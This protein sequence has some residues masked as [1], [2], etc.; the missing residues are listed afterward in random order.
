[1][2]NDLIRDLGLSKELL[3]L[4][5]SRLY[6]KNMLQK[7]TNV[8]FYREREK[9]LLLSFEPD[10]NFVYCCD[11]TGLLVAMGVPQYDANEWRLFIVRR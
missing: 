2:I 8:T 9:G 4:L 3:E 10:N 6:K 11:V 5:A 7:E 1:M